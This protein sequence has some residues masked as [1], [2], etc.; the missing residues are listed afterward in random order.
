MYLQEWIKWRE[1]TEEG[2]DAVPNGAKASQA[3]AAAA[4]EA[5]QKD[6]KNKFILVPSDHA[7]ANTPCPICQE[8]F[9]KSY[10]DS[11]SD[12]VWKDAIKIGSRVYHA[13]E[14]A[15]LKSDGGHTPNRT[16][17]PDSVLG[18]RGREVSSAPGVRINP[19]LEVARHLPFTMEN[20][21]MLSTGRGNHSSFQNIEGRL[22]DH[23]MLSD[24]AFPSPSSELPGSYPQLESWLSLFASL[25]Q[26]PAI[27][28]S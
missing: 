15:E 20:G 10:D 13:S 9:E 1:V 14:Y 17:T 23:G 6:P 11:I 4:A 18:K 26:R 22:R 3:Q 28:I 21:L 25:L 8:P 7:L 16:S 19:Q 2:E 24:T 12:W 27:A 5:A